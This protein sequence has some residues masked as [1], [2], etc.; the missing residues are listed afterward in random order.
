MAEE[1]QGPTKQLGSRIPADLHKRAQHAA[2]DLDM[3]LEKFVIEAIED[4]VGKFESDRNGKATPPPK[5]GR[6]PKK[7]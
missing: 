4:R 7:P 1:Y 3:T 2:L 6:P 5:R